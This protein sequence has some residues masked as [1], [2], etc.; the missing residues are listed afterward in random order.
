MKCGVRREKF[1]SK[2]NERRMSAGEDNV[3]DK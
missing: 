3:T 2:Q 1:V